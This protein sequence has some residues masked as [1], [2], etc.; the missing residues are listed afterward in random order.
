MVG[1]LD[2]LITH[3]KI[4]FGYPV[5]NMELEQTELDLA[6]EKATELILENRQTFMSDNNLTE[7]EANEI[8]KRITPNVESLLFRQTLRGVVKYDT[9]RIL[10]KHP[11][12]DSQLKS[13]MDEGSYEVEQALKRQTFM[14]SRLFESKG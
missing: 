10:I 12:T 5:R 4:S 8:I 1:D 11:F 2:K 13:L 3:L 6:I 14:L 9:K 7:E